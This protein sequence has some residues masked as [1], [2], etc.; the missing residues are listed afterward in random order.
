MKQIAVLYG[1]GTIS[2]VATAG[3]RV[4]NGKIDLVAELQKHK[5][6]QTLD[7]LQLENPVIVYEGLSENIDTRYQN[8]IFQHIR[9][10]I[11]SGNYHGIL[12]TFG[13]DA[14]C[15]MAKL[16]ELTFEKILN[17]HKITLIITGANQDIAHPQT[18]AWDNLYLALSSFKKSDAGV[19][20][21]F[22][23]RLIRAS[24]A[25]MEPFNTAM[26]FSD[27]EDSHYILLNQYRADSRKYFAEK[28]PYVTPKA[29]VYHVNTT[30]ITTH[31]P[32]LE[33]IAQ[34]KM[35]VVIFVLFHSGTANVE[36]E[37]IS[38]VRLIRT[39]IHDYQVL[40]LG[41]TENGE[42][43][44]LNG[45]ETSIAL[46]QAGLIPLNMDYQ[47]ALAKANWLLESLQINHADEFI[48]LMLFN[49]FGEIKNPLLTKYQ[50][51]EY[52][53]QYADLWKK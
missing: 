22:G 34:N 10:T 19:F 42:P 25:V 14:M 1:G 52:Q 41:T 45:Y 30:Q 5:P 27:K 12:L 50:I 36:N 51:Q 47:T 17:Y 7:F 32:L 11:D 15:E 2:S 28:F 16:I 46:R 26:R 6:I 31:L 44:T 8:I 33:T 40:C 3:Y 23:G 39:L 35:C 4:A 9:K 49:H 29:T 38:A 13:T 18:D 48:G 21:A 53:T 24:Q 43:T 20:I 37:Q